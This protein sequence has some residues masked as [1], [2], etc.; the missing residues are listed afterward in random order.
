M[1]KIAL[2]LIYNIFVTKFFFQELT[3]WIDSVGWYQTNIFLSLVLF[4][5]IKVKKK[6]NEKNSKFSF[7]YKKIKLH[8]PSKSYWSKM[9]GRPEKSLTIKWVYLTKW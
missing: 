5:K 6:N 1:E 8:Q 2:I 4:T 3:F 9:F 7:N